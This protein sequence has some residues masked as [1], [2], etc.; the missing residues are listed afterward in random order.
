[1]NDVLFDSRE[2]PD[3]DTMIKVT[4]MVSTVLKNHFPWTSEQ[5]T[6]IVSL[7]L[8]FVP[9]NADQTRAILEHVE[10]I[11]REKIN[12]CVSRKE[13]EHEGRRKEN[14]DDP[15]ENDDECVDKRP[16]DDSSLYK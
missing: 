1:M 10:D 14:D 11:L 12:A 16:N 8:F 4:H 6:R 9:L 13:N 5:Q 15:N 7:V 2:D 3:D